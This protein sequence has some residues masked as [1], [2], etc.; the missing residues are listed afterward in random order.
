MPTIAHGFASVGKMV[1]EIFSPGVTVTE[2]GVGELGEKTETLGVRPGRHER[3]ETLRERAKG[4]L[5]T[6]DGR[7][8]MV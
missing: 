6:L 3:A 1:A 4:A 8:S 5:V 7:Q 2:R